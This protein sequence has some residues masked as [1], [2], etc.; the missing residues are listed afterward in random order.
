[1][2]VNVVRGM[3]KMT[4]DSGW[5]FGGLKTLIRKNDISASV[6]SRLGRD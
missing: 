3:L 4:S 6:D 2:S 5:N 1:M